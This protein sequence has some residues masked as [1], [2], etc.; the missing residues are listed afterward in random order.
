M[1]NQKTMK[2][3]Y[4]FIAALS[5]VFLFAGCKKEE[6]ATGSDPYNS[7]PLTVVGAVPSGFTQKVVIE[8]FTGEWCV[9]CPDGAARLK[10]V[11]DAHPNKAIAAEIHQNDWLEISQFSVL[12]KHLGG[13]I[14]FPRAA[15]NRLHATQTINPNQDGFLV[16]SRGNWAAAT[17]RLLQEEAKAGLALITRLNGG[18]LD[19]KVLAA[20]NTDVEKETRLTVYI[21]EDG[22]VAKNQT[23]ASAGYTHYHVLR[24]VASEGIGDII[25]LNK[26]GSLVVKEYK[27]IDVSGYNTANLKVIAFVNVMPT[28]TDNERRILN[29]QEVKAGQI[30]KWD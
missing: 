6:P 1:T 15:L 14:G 11:L 17:D 29:G 24:K 13:I 5:A 18:K 25:D 23:G 19:I 26:A 16:I 28:S 4:L 10:E 27:N 20:S 8:K 9:N 12:D 2:L 21:L 22:I 3:K 7:D 30:K